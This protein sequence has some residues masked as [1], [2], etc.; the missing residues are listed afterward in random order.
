MRQERRVEFDELLLLGAAGRQ[1]LAE[2]AVAVE[3][4]DADDRHAEVAGRL[5]VVAGQDPE[6][7]RVLRQRLAEAELG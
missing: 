4:A 5:E 6:A 2:V 1:Q 3:E 7:A